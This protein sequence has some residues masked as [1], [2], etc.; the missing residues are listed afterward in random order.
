MSQCGK[1]NK[2]YEEFELMWMNIKQKL[3]LLCKECIKEETEAGNVAPTTK[4]SS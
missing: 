4:T 3:K 2:N 1:C